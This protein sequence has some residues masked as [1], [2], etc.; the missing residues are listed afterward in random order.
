V[1][2]TDDIQPT[3]DFDT[4]T[5]VRRGDGGALLAELD[6]TWQVGGGILN[7]GYLLSVAARAAVSESPHPHPVAVAAS[8][9]RPTPAGTATLEVTPGAAGRTLAHSVVT[10]SASGAGPSLVVQATTATLGDEAPEYVDAPMPVIPPPDECVDL[11]ARLSPDPEKR[12]GLH[13]HVD[14][15][16]DPAT[17]GW[18]VG[19]PSDEPVVRA[20]VRFVDG[21]PADPV[22]LLTFADVLPPLG[23]VLGQRGWAPTV[24]LQVL[25]RAMPA[26]GWCLA[27]ASARQIA[28][29]WID[30]DCTI[31]DSTGRLVV[32]ARQLARLSR[33]R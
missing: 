25:V 24:Q 20:W 13:R 5:A 23:F 33:G 4:A 6:Q 10:L 1:P 11:A 31:W 16:L 32:Q 15:R 9:I 30:E 14:I 21:H 3:Y 7:G 29:G 19:E 28:G 27:E 12:P 2:Q 8:Y 17:A 22:A 18:T 26:P